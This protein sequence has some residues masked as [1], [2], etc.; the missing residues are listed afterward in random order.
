MQRVPEAELMQ[1]PEQVQAYAEADFSAS[2]AHFIALVQQHAG[3]DFQGYALDLGCG[4]GDI[5]YRLA[6]K[7]PALQ[8]HGV[9]GAQPMLDYAQLHTPKNLK[10]RVRFM[11][12]V[13][14]SHNLAQSEYEL[15]T[16]NSLLHHLRD[17]QVLWQC[18]KQ[19]AKPGTKICIM[20]LI[21]PETTHDAKRIVQQYAAS[22]A[23]QLKI[24]FYNSLMA[25]YT[26]DEI[27]QQ[28][29]R[30]NLDFEVQQVSDRHVFIFGN[31]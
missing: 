31:Y 19:F 3:S 15:I 9:D 17:A 20:D 10:T 27:K 21:R 5:C 12:A 22:E 24:D 16:S 23:E 30:A 2:N 13:L 1:Q 18:V 26:L 14:P 8:V 28:L 25:A 4:P 29:E 7:F 11:L 6:A